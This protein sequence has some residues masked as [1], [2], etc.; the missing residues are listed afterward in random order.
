MTFTRF[1]IMA[2]F[3][4]ITGCTA[5]NVREGIYQGMY[6]GARIENNREMTPAERASR[7][8]PDYNQYSTGRKERI[9]NEVP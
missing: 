7:P 4:L 9:G 6:E 3:M 5:Q 8:D 2:T 1:M